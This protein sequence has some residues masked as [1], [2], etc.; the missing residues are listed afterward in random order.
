MFISQSVFSFNPPRHA[1]TDYAS[2]SSVRL[3]AHPCSV[4]IV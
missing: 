1:R 3:S 2:M 4:T